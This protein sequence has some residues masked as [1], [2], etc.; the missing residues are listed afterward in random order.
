MCS[1]GS[2]TE[3]PWNQKA[4]CW[5]S[6]SPWSAVTITSVSS[7]SPAFSSAA[8]IRPIRSSVARTPPS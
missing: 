7:A 4:L 1:T 6:S 2:C 3:L 5:P 8:T